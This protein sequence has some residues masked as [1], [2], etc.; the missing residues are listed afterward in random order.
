MKLPCYDCGWDTRREYYMVHDAIWLAA[1]MTKSR[2]Q[3]TGEYLCVPCLE[4]RIGRGLLPEDFTAYPVNDP[5]YPRRPS[6]LAKRHA[7]Q[8]VLVLSNLV[9]AEPSRPLRD[10]PTSPCSGPIGE[11][12][13]GSR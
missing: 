4:E 11:H 3:G 9:N 7:G 6:R 12:R 1:G 8:L 13:G 10:R 2:Y 5:P